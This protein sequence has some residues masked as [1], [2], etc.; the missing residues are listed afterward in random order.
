MRIT[1]L[2]AVVAAVVLP[3]FGETVDLGGN[4]HLKYTLPQGWE[5]K[6][7]QAGSQG[8]HVELRPTT[9]VNAACRLTIVTLPQPTP[10]PDDKIIEGFEKGLSGLLANAVETEVKL[11]KIPVAGGFGVYA[12]FTDA[13]LV[14]KPAKPDN[15]KIMVPVMI[16]LSNT[17]LVTATVF[18]DE[19]D[20]KEMKELIKM[21]ETLKLDSSV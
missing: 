3:A 2:L 5:V 11:Q 1:T 9:E 17:I 4:G 12:V 8:T 6:S 7:T 20:G 21:L 18:S 16:K 14:D 19:K 10:L 13:S 15:F